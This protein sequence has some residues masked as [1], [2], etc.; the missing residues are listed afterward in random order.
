MKHV[1]LVFTSVVKLWEFAQ[2]LDK[3]QV[4]IDPKLRTLKCYCSTADIERAILSY[5]ATEQTQKK[6]GL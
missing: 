6:N 5:G 4:E 3:T 2:S 1:T